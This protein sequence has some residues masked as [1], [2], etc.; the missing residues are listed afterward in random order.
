M[1]SLDKIIKVVLIA[2]LIIAVLSVIYLVVIHN[3]GQD[4]SEFYI[5]DSNYNT[6]NYP[7]NLTVGE[8]GELIIGIQNQEHELTNYTVEI[9]KDGKLINKFNKTL[10]NHERV[11]TP[12]YFKADKSGEKQEMELTLYK[13]NMTNPYR[14]LSFKYNVYQ[15]KNKIG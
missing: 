4:Y 6:S 5:L 2:I 8:S 10:T 9:M 15:W 11:E 1:N 12:F 14:T 13:N 3:P 7:N